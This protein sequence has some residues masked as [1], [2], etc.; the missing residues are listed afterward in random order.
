[1]KKISL[2]LAIVLTF[3]MALAACAPAAPNDTT[4]STN[5]SKPTEP[6]NSKPEPAVYDSMAEFHKENGQEG[7]WQYYFSGDNGKTL[8]PCTTYDVYDGGIEGWH[9]WEGSYI[10]VCLNGDKEGWI[11]LNTDCHSENFTGQMGVLVFEAPADGKYVLTAA[12]WNPWEQNCEK[13]TFRHSDGTVI[14]EQDMTELVANYGYITPTDVELKAGDRILMYCNA[15]GGDW[16]SAYIQAKIYYEPADDSCYEIP[17][18][19]EI[20]DEPEFVPE[21]EGAEHSAV[22]EFDIENADGLWVYASTFDGKEYTVMSKYDEPD[23]SGDGVADAKQWYSENGTGMGFNLD[24]ANWIEANVT[25]S[26]ENG[27]EITA[28][29]FKAP[30]AGTYKLTIF[31]QNKWSQNGGDVVVSVNGEDVATVG[32][33][34]EVTTQEVEVTLEAGEIAYIHGTSNGGWVST[35]IAVFVG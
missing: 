21:V 32:F 4:P 8:D 30:E 11:E 14:Y 1:M 26:M 7:V 16:V 2:I 33:A 12:V 10:G 15:A 22:E 31:T 24:A 23:W 25:D 19:P 27:G 17:E 28:L 18:I 9:P 20:P 5:P 13:F 6:V 29:G 3:A 35:Y 34:E